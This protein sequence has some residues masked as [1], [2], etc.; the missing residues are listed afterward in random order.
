MYHTNVKQSWLLLLIF[1]LCSRHSLAQISRGQWLTGG[2][3]AFS[4]Y[5]FYTDKI[6]SISAS[7]SAGYFFLNHLAAGVRVG[8]NFQSDSYPSNPKSTIT[9]ISILPFVRYYFLP[10]EQPINLF[11]DAGYGYSFGKYKTANYPDLKYNSSIISI[12]AGPV[13]FLNPHTSLELTFGYDH[14]IAGHLGDTLAV[15]S[16]QV[17]VGFQI[18]LGR[19]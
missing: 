15:N 13:L 3:A 16:F 12:K 17:G 6:T 2:N 18:H 5:K 1:I 10:A 9:F 19:R 11:A 7:P 8:Y 14:S 4:S